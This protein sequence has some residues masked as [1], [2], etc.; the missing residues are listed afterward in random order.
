[1]PDI[2]I[3]PVWRQVTIRALIVFLALLADPY[4]VQFF[5]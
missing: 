3:V 5:A 1:L 2:E 4:F